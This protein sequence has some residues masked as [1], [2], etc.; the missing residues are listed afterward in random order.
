MMRTTSPVGPPSPNFFITPAG[1]RL[2]HDV[3][4][5]V[6]RAHKHVGFSVESGLEPGTLRCRIRNLSTRP[7]YFLHNTTTKALYCLSALL[8]QWRPWA[9]GQLAQWV[10]L[11][12]SP[13]YVNLSLERCC[14][15][16]FFLITGHL[17]PGHGD[18]SIVRIAV[19]AV[20]VFETLLVFLNERAAI[21][22]RSIHA[23]NLILSK[24]SVA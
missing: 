10:K 18:E 23:T 9:T 15:A 6:H 8:D 14:T 7:L 19:Q 20:V 5:S 22:K 2:M 11:P 21:L 3:R 4:V 1:G 12:C 16:F 24:V 13:E 17:A